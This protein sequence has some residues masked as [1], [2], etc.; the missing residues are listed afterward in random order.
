MASPT[1]CELL[2]IVTSALLVLL[3]RSSD[4]EWLSDPPGE[5]LQSAA[6]FWTQAWRWRRW[7]VLACRDAETKDTALGIHLS[8][9][10]RPLRD[11]L[12]KRGHLVRVRTSL[13]L[14]LQN[15]R[16]RNTGAKMKVKLLPE[17][18]Q[19]SWDVFL[20]VISRYGHL[21]NS[22]GNLLDTYT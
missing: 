14:G 21:T 18:I 4:G 19:T 5:S 8:K 17:I 20:A 22:S 1:K 6:V 12:R 2:A 13:I 7:W 3:S 10:A 9:G 16:A 15:I 11:L